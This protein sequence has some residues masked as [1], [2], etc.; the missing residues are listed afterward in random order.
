MLLHL[1]TSNHTLSTPESPRSRN[2]FA[3][4]REWPHVIRNGDVAVKIY[5]NNGHVRGRNFRTFVVSYYANGARQLRRFTDFASANAAADR[6]AN[7]KAQGSLGAAALSP[8]DRVSLEQALALL[9][10]VAK[11][12]LLGGQWPR[13]AQCN[14]RR[15]FCK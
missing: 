9:P 6:I 11:R 10:P 5:R 13:H 15:S 12:C 8:K 14:H 4:P 7:E 1:A 3:P 2:L